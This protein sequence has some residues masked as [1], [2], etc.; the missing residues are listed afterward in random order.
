MGLAASQARFLG[1]TARKASCEFKSTELAQTKM[2]LTNQMSDIANEYA[3]S[4]NSTKLIWQNETVGGTYNMSYGLLMSPGYLNDFN[5]YMI[6]SPSGAI[7]L[8]DRFAQAAKDAGITMSGGVPSKDGRDAFIA[9]LAGNGVITNETSEIVKSQAWDYT[10]GMGG[11]ILD[12]NTVDVYDLS[13]VIEDPD[14]GG[15]T[16]PW[17]ISGVSE[18]DGKTINDYVNSKSAD[19]KNAAKILF[20]VDDKTNIENDKTYSLI[21]SDKYGEIIEDYNNQISEMQDKVSEA[22]KIINDETSDA[23]SKAQA[24]I[25]KSNAEQSLNNLTSGKDAIENSYNYYN[26]K[27]V[28]GMFS[29]ESKLVTNTSSELIN[30]YSLIQ[31][32]SINKDSSRIASITF[33][34]LLT[35]EIVLAVRYNDDSKKAVQNKFID[36]ATDILETLKKTFEAKFGYNIDD[37]SAQAIDYAWTMV[38]RNFLNIGN[39][40]NLN[41]TKTDDTVASNSAYKNASENNRIG[42]DNSDIALSL[43][44]AAKAFLTY[45]A[46]VVNSELDF[47]VAKSVDMSKYVT[48]SIDYVYLGQSKENEIPQ[49]EKLSDFYNQLYNNICAHGWRKDDSVNQDDYLE[50]MIKNGRYSVSA[51]SSD[52]YYY[53]V[54]YNSISYLQEVV[55]QDAIA[56]AEAKYSQKKAE[57]T[58]KENEIDIK[59]KKLDSEIAALTQELESVKQLISNGINKAFSTFSN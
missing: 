52:G 2:E 10:A 28:S 38:K 39:A 24:A 59:S 54:Q 49:E 26:S 11:L 25:D 56:R 12:K 17:G 58:A 16:I 35:D 23:A 53:Q 37:M 14:F 4:L 21:G 5:P 44:N 36:E 1:I 19:Y 40:V 51:L 22:D 50:N 43:S 31:N 42:L 6:T 29:L 9:A 13:A 27:L 30:K 8:D 41:P 48:S 45:Y 55:D 15:K 46:N 3:H 33:G 7:V 32:G 57:I 47:G 18:F 34:D 20:E